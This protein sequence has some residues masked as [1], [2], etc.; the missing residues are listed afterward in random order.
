MSRFHAGPFCTKHEMAGVLHECRFAGGMSASGQLAGFGGYFFVRDLCRV[1]RDVIGLRGYESFTREMLG[2]LPQWQGI[3]TDPLTNEFPDAMP[4]QVFRQYVGGRLLP[5][6][7]LEDA[8]YWTNLWGIP[9]E[10]HELHG[11]HFVTYNCSDGP[12]LY[13]ITLGK[14]CRVYGRAVLKDS[15]RHWPTGTNRTVA[16]AARRCADYI[17]QAVKRSEDNGF[18]LYAVPNTNPL[19]TSPSG[20]MRDGFDAYVRSDG[21]PADYN[22][23]AYVENQALAYEALLFAAE[24]LPEDTAVKSWLSLAEELRRRALEQLWME[25]TNFFAAAIDR[26]GQVD[27]ISSAVFE[28]LN[29]PFFE[30]L[31]DGPAYVETLVKKL[32]SPDFMTAIGTRMTS[33]EHRQ[34]EGEYYAYQGS[35]AVWYVTNGIVATGLSKWHLNAAASDLGKRRL[36]G[37]IDRSGEALELDYVDRTTGEP[38][39]SPVDKPASGVSTGEELC[40]SELGQKD[41]A[42]TAS[43]ALRQLHADYDSRAPAGSWQR[44]LDD[45]AARQARLMSAAHEIK[46][47]GRLYVNLGKGKELKRQRAK[48]LGAAA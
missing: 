40:P 35:G 28:T 41:Q 12:L 33:L 46:S 44:V 9:M 27:M 39:F 47:T 7:R 20:V 29:G 21:T 31:K 3:K 24:F 26:H 6:D 48:A 1:L 4:H 14:F 34:L 11:A 17:V 43:A 30:D 2:I 8:Q 23:V 32:Y 45:W 15:F 16:E 13:L 22:F 5:D 42:W 10:S 38:L 36:I 37:G 19:Q 25:K 18:G